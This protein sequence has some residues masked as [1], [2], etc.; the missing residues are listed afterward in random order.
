MQTLRAN[1]NSD[2]VLYVYILFTIFANGQLSD[3][4]WMRSFRLRK[5]ASLYFV[6]TI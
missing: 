2:L 3:D 6:V 5:C 1:A 4:D